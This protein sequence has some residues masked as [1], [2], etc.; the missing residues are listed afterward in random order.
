MRTNAGYVGHRRRAARRS[1]VKSAAGREIA[2][3]PDVVDPA[4]RRRAKHDLLFALRSYFPARFNLRFSADQRAVVRK[5]EKTVKHGGL[6]AF[7]LPRGSG[8]TTIVESSALMAA[9]FGW[10]RFIVIVSSSS[11]GAQKILDSVRVELETNTM[12]LED[13]PE[14]CYPVRRLDGIAHRCRGQTYRGVRT[15]VGWGGNQIILPTIEGVG[16]QVI[17]PIGITGSIRGTKAT[18]ASTGEVVRPDLVLIDDFQTD[19]SARSPARCAAHVEK[20]NGA[21]LG[22]AGPAK[23]IACFLTA[24]VLSV[25]DAAGRLLDNELWNPERSQ[26]LKKW[27]DDMGKWDKYA[28]VVRESIA[29][30]DGLK[31]ATDFYRKNKRSMDKGAQ[32]AWS[33]RYNED[34]I[35]A[36]QHAM[37][38]YYRDP[39][40]FLSEYQLE[41]SDEKK[42]VMDGML[43]AG[44]IAARTNY[45]EAGELPDDT[46]RLVAFVDVQ[47]R[48]L[49]YA[50]FAV[51]EDFKVYCVEYSTS[52]EQG[53][54]YFTYSQIR[55]S[56]Q[57][58]FSDITELSSLIVAGITALL[59]KLFAK[60]S[61]DRVLI[62]AGWETS[63]VNLAVASSE[64][65]A[66]VFASHGRGITAGRQSLSSLAR[67]PGEIVGAEWRVRR[68]AGSRTRYVVF[69][70]NY[71]KTQLHRRFSISWP[72]PGAITLYKGGREKTKHEMVA[73]HL[74][75]EVPTK[76]KGQ[77]RE[78][79]EWHLLP[80]RDNHW[81]DC[82]V[83]GLVAASVAG[84]QLPVERVADGV[85]SGRRK[86]SLRDTYRGVSS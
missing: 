72:D 33:D 55:R 37:T 15:H 26:M 58:K 82:F 67:K 31:R 34:E 25:D 73:D 38:L 49:Y 54:G 6:N 69:D 1:A 63:A 17:R 59:G 2:P 50:V 21:L 65:R 4:R 84:A 44:E 42:A 41:P 78:V 62:D 51:S 74:T 64:Y 19:E 85:A 10:R 40:A 20:I 16:G 29:A 7:G 11:E 23:K 86:V 66:S 32:A 24:T 5:I 13:F 22:L 57:R 18:L 52:P 68:S 71:W 77:G 81:L 83:G 9:L 39:G 79:L 76:T 46:T 28:D 70:A 48:C 47:E 56:L 36:I 35:S 12:L 61:I 45:L 30:G 60:Y 3:M 43:S 53:R 14:V 80:S 27:P 8:K 75:S